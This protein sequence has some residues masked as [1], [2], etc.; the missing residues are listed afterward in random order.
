M[1]SNRR[2]ALLTVS[3]LIVALN[4]HAQSIGEGIKMYNY[5]K[6]K[7]AIKILQ[8]LSATDPRA[9]YYL[10]LAYLDDGNIAMAQAAFSKFPEDPANISGTARVAFAQK[11]PVKAMQILKD[12]VAKAKKKDVEQFRFA[13]DAIIYS[14]GGDYFQAIS[15]DSTVVKR[16]TKDAQLFIALGD[17]LMKTPGGGGEAMNNYENVRDNFP[18]KSLAYSRIGDTWLGPRNDLALE[19]Y[20]KAKETDS[21]NPLPYHALAQAY[22]Y[23][24]QY[25]LAMQNMKRYM[26]LSDNSFEDKKLNIEL[27]YQSKN[28]CEAI[29]LT[30]ELMKTPALPDSVLTEFYG[31]LGYSQAFCGDSMLAISN[32]RTYLNREKTERKRGAVYFDFGKVWMKVG[33][34]DSA[35]FYYGLG[36]ATDSTADKAGKF[37]EIADAFRLKKNYVKAAIW[38]DSLIKSAPGAEPADYF[39]RGYMLYYNSDYQKSLEAFQD[40]EKKYPEQPQAL[41]MQG[42]V[43]TLIDSESKTGTGEAAFLKYLDKFE[44]TAK[45][46]EMKIAYS[47][48]VAY[49]FNS[50]N[51]EKLP[52]YKEKLRALDANNATLLQIEAIEK[53]RANPKKAPVKTPAKGK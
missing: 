1:N 41:Y 2:I 18:E 14:K 4:V 7:S 34:L 38:Y 22:Q 10:G 31:V 40:Y 28:F 17:A 20:R 36:V 47:Y 32:I 52:I 53:E 37:R 13:A 33:D 5:K 19:N 3:A 48:L 8:P 51:K 42:K 44:K 46:N 29:P 39:W 12:L 43:A 49:Y 27:L 45:P 11:D 16:G 35:A 6:I 23:S 50:E 26:E 24:G 15:W 30:N 21:T 9:N 25:K